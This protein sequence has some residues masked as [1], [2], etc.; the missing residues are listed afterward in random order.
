[1]ALIRGSL[2]AI[3]GGLIGAAIWAAIAYF[4]QISIGYIAVGVGFLA[5]LGMSIG[6]GDE[7]S[8]EH[9][10]VAAI[11]AIAAIAAGKYFTVLALVADAFPSAS[12]ITG[13][14][15]FTDD[16][17]K[18]CIADQLVE[19]SNADGKVLKWPNGKS[20]EDAES[21]A[22]YPIE[23]VKDAESRWSAMS[24]DEQEKYKSAAAES[25]EHVIGN[26]VTG[27]RSVATTQAFKDSM[28]RP[29]TILWIIL[30]AGAAFKVGSG[31][32][33]D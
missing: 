26:A 14:Y 16:D 29:F 9:G 31:L 21:L 4:A 24:Q 3:I 15:Q 30:A 18:V 7:A 10:V 28:L 8:T 6:A 2:F 25:V 19:Q 1:M 20:P 22:D 23:I 5:G 33:E 11:I 13:N 12:T 27:A 32:N 17:A